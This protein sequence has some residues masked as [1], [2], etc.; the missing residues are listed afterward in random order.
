MTDDEETDPSNTDCADN[1]P[2]PTPPTDFD[3]DLT[4]G[5][6]AVLSWDEPS[7]G[8]PDDYLIYRR[9]GNGSW[10]SIEE[11]DGSQTSWT[12]EDPPGDEL[13]YRVKA[14]TDNDKT[15][16]S[17]SDCVDNTPPPVPPTGLDVDLAYADRASL[18]WDE[19]ETGE[20]DEYRIYRR[21][22]GS[23]WDDI[24]DVDGAERTWTDD[25]PP[26]DELCYRVSAITDSE[27]TD[28]SGSECVDNTPIPPPSRPRGLEVAAQSLP[29]TPAS[30]I[31]AFDGSGQILDDA[32]GNGHYAMRG[33]TEASANDDPS[34]VSGV[35]GTALDFDGK[36]V[37]HRH[38]LSGTRDPG[39]PYRGSV[40]SPG[41]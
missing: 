25:N 15:S 33:G 24:E 27:E 36:R 26:A 30:I 37:R 40:D 13:C 18:S 7:T 16:A 11:I 3:V 21:V 6:Y 17:N 1:T 14:V 10:D 22:D 28:P 4:Y 41:R 32:S 8:E 20:P 9:E 23:S 5:E 19:P 35:S 29:D 12:D 38:E 2:I 31:L 39:E 34:W